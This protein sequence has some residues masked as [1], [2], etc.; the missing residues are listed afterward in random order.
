MAGL[1]GFEPP[2]P[3]FGDRCSS[4]TEL[5]ACLVVAGEQRQPPSALRL[6]PGLF[7]LRVLAAEWTELLELHT[8]RMEPLVLRRDVVPPLAVVARQ[9]DLVPHDSLLRLLD[10]LGNDAGA[11]RAPALAD[12]EP[13]PVFHRD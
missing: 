1:E 6:L 8:I 4:R 7:V 13:Q 5:Q 2:T 12:R 11:D 10:D 3:G 9:G